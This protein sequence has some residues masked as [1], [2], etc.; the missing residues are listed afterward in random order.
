M[1]VGFHLAFLA[2]LGN[3]YIS[4]IHVVQY[5]AWDAICSLTQA[6]TVLA[7][8]LLVTMCLLREATAIGFSIETG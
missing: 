7:V 3:I 6:F 8:C 1:F 4:W 5:V 2:L